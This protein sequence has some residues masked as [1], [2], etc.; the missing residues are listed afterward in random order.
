MTAP[1]TRLIPY[2]STP[3]FDQDTLP[4]GLRREH[5]TKAGVWGII[6]VFE[7]RVRYHVV[8]PVSDSLLDS[9]HPGLIFPDQPHFVEPAGPVRMRVEFRVSDPG[10]QP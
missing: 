1:V 3:V 2:K 6:R 10:T 9:R 8:D 7:G 4:G 5:R